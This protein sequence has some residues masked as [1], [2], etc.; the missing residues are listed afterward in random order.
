MS[1]EIKNV[2]EGFHV[3]FDKSDM[4]KIYRVSLLI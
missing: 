3:L 1:G 4:S 2:N